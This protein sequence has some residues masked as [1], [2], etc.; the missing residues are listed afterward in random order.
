MDDIAEGDT[1]WL[2]YL[3][4][5]Y[6]GQQGLET[7]VKEKEAQI[8]PRLASQVGFTDLPAEIRIGQFGPFLARGEDGDR[9]TAGLP[10]SLPPADLDA[11]MVEKLLTQK[12]EGPEIVGEDPQA[13]SR[14][15]SKLGLMARTCNWVMKGK[16]SRRNRN[17]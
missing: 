12:E 14:S 8:D 17:G 16:A 1:G 6:Q 7:Q 4:R 10:D 13:A 9:V 11:E 15:T 2:E 3:R 5:F